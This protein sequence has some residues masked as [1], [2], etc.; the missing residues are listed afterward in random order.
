MLLREQNATMSM[1]RSRDPS[2]CLF[3]I[4]PFA[5]YDTLNGNMDLRLATSG[6]RGKGQSCHELVDVR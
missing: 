3:V 2:M 1:N 4:D 6:K 5:R